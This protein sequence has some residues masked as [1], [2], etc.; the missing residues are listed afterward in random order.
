LA[1]SG[2]RLRII[3]GSAG[4]RRLKPAPEGVRPTS[5]LVR[6]AIFDVLEATSADFSR[7]L[8]LYAGS[9]A[10]G[11]EALSRGAEWCDFVDKQQACVDVIKANLA[12]A[13][14][15]DKAKV[16][17]IGAER[18]AGRLE[19][20]YSLVFAD[21]PYNDDAAS[22]TISKLGDTALIGKG[23][24]LVVEHSTRRTPAESIGPLYRVWSR[25]YGDTHVTI[26]RGV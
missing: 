21:P 16:W 9:G 22:R 17:K 14:L 25:R 19:G 12:M 2:A 8:D 3:S 5:D 6:G 10:M 18:A 7:V 1:R 24:T 13:G 26:Y 20:P 11:I 23:T 4:G 15:A